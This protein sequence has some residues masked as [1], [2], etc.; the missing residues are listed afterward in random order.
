MKKIN[1]LQLCN[2]IVAIYKQHST[3]EGIIIEVQMA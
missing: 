1:T 2:S 3:Y